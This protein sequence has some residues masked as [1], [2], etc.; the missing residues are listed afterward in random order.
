M[1]IY[2]PGG[3]AST[4]DYGPY[5]NYGTLRFNGDAGNEGSGM[6]WAAVAGAAGSV[7]GGILDSR[8]QN[9]ATDAQTAA[10][11]EA[12]AFEREQAAKGEAA[13]AQQWEQWNASRNALLERYGIDIAP[14]QMPGPGGPAGP[15]GAPGGPPGGPGGAQPR[16]AMPPQMADAK[17]IN[18]AQG[19]NL[20]QLGNWNWEGQG[21]GRRA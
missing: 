8:S 18:P 6:P 2:N 20:G 1:P 7:I 3:Y 13:Y 10:N 11:R 19:Q 15:G 12:M 5:G 4:M 14:P 21:L 9:R 17:G 16:G